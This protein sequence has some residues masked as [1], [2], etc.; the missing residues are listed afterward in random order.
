[1]KAHLAAKPTTMVHDLHN[2]GRDREYREVD[3]EFGFQYSTTMMKSKARK[4]T[5]VHKKALSGKGEIMYI[6]S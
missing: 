2:M 4:P 1:M 6:D 5:P 3:R